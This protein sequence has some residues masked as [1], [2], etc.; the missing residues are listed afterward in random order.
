[1]KAPII[2][3]VAIMMLTLLLVLPAPVNAMNEIA[4]V[5]H[6]RDL[7]TAEWMAPNGTLMRGVTGKGVGVAIIDTGLDGTH[8]DFAGRIVYNGRYVPE[9]GW[10]ELVDTDLD[11][12]GQGHGTFN[13]GIIGGSGANS[14]GVYKGIAPECSLICLSIDAVAYP[15]VLFEEIADEW[16]YHN[17][18]AHNI[19]ITSNS[20]GEAGSSTLS[21]ELKSIKEKKILYVFC[22]GNG[23]GNGNQDNTGNYKHPLGAMTVGGCWKDGETMWGGSSTGYKNDVSTWP[24]I[25]A[26]SCLIVSTFA[27]NAIAVPYL[28]L[29]PND[30]ELV[31]NGYVR[32]YGNGT[33]FS[34]P[35]VTGVAAL[36]FQVNPNLTSA[37]AMKI[38]ELTAD[39]IFGPYNETGWQSGYG[40]VN[41][42]RAVA[43]SNYMALRQES[44]IAEALQYYRIGWKDKVMVLNPSPLPEISLEEKSQFKDNLE[45][46]IREFPDAITYGNESNILRLYM[47]E[48][49]TLSKT[50]PATNEDKLIKLQ[51]LQYTTFDVELDSNITLRKGKRTM[52]LKFYAAT[53]SI[54]AG[55]SLLFEIFGDNGKIGDG[56]CYPYLESDLKFVANAFYSLDAYLSI[57]ENVSITN[58]DEFEIRVTPYFTATNSAIGNLYLVVDSIDHP[59]GIKLITLPNE[60][61]I[62]KPATDMPRQHKSSFIP[63]FEFV[64]TLIMVCILS[65]HMKRS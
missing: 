28:L 47:K 8:P 39:P 17:A 12:A 57:Y 22:A 46:E 62:Q 52:Y 33:S 56:W 23:G 42:A 26:P 18:D 21:R 9:I 53:D 10:I 15:L 30:Y 55:L 32:G 54:S 65:F 63:G 44:T 13:T 1:M 4:N 51:T 35:V 43:V 49:C 2:Q 59:S 14:D 3:A 58:K 34:T 7:W 20:Y 40:L 45:E 37:Q 64:S 29:Y 60:T 25:T 31:L 11:Q 16:I 6:V 36:V 48:N 5:I 19:K 27:K 38:I 24:S 61:E 41:A 50:S